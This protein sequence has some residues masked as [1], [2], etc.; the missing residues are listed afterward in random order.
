MG[1]WAAPLGSPSCREASPVSVLP[2]AVRESSGVAVAGAPGVTFPPPPTAGWE[3]GPG[4]FWTH[5]DSGWPAEIFRVTTDGVLM[6]RVQVS[7][8]DNVDWEDMAAGPCPD[9]DGAGER[10]LYLAD[11]GDN[12][13][14]RASL[15]IYRIRE[16][17]PGATRSEPAQRLRLRLP[18]G[19]RDIE[20]LILLENE[21]FLLVTKGR[22]HAVEVYLLDPAEAA[23]VEWFAADP[24][25]VFEARRVQTLTSGPPGWR[26]LV[27]GAAAAP[28]EEGGWL[29]ALRTYQSLQFFRVSLH[30]GDGPLVEI[31]GGE[32]SLLHLREPQG[33]AVGFAGG[34][35]IVLTS[36]GG[37]AGGPASMRRLDCSV[38]FGRWGV[39]PLER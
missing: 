9:A 32:M 21:T 24:A 23:D 15:D 26:G 18:H 11:T 5:N 3:S 31:P 29:V 34:G 8:S 17:G 33:E 13:E 10:C 7:G 30:A 16:P 4:T 25:V 36:E 19:P 20:A 38:G 1:A 35:F 12:L 28:L 22:N 27:T 2:D 37:L 6:D 39:A 14:R